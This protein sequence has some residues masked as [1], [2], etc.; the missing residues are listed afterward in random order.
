MSPAEGKFREAHEFALFAFDEPPVRTGVPDTV[1]TTYLEAVDGVGPVLAA[2]LRLVGVRSWSDLSVHSRNMRGEPG[3][4][5]E[6]AVGRLLDAIESSDVRAIASLIPKREHWRLACH[7][8]RQ[9]V[10]LDIETTGL[11]RFYHEI[12]LV[13]WSLGGDYRCMVAPIREAEKIELDE[14]LTGNVV[15]VTF[16]GSHFDLPFIRDHAGVT[17]GDVVHVDLRHLGA[18]CGLRG[19][20]KKIER[21]LGLVREGDERMTGEE[22]PALWFLFQ[23]GDRHALEAL[24]GYNHADV[25]GMRVILEWCSEAIAGNRSTFPKTDLS[26]WGKGSSFA[27]W[28]G[29]FEGLVGPRMRVSDLSDRAQQIV[30]VG[31]DLAGSA[32]GNTGWCRVHGAAAETLALRSDDEIMALTISAN[33]DLVSIDAPLSLPFGR[34]TPF[35]DDP[36]RKKFGIA[37]ECERIL[38]SR[39]VNTY[40]SLIFSMQKL[41]ERGSQLAGELRRQGIPVIESFPGAAQDM[42]GVPR[43]GLDK[44]FL[45]ISLAEYGFEGDWLDQV[46][47]HDE[48]DALTSALVGQMFWSGL[49]ELLGNEHED[50]M[51][52]PSLDMRHA[53]SAVF[54]VSGRTGAGKSTLAARLVSKGLETV[55]FSAALSDLFEGEHNRRP[56]RPELSAFG[57]EILRTGRQRELSAMVAHAVPTGKPCVVDGV[58]RPEDYTTL[59]ERF[60]AAYVHVH[61]AID[62]A[63]RVT[64]LDTRDHEE[65]GAV[66]NFTSEI[67]ARIDVLEERA[68][69]LFDNSGTVRALSGF[70]DTLVK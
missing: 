65:A 20:Q 51:V 58:R 13:G 62:E 15:V 47:T 14:I 67:E 44:K 2:K 56:T 4:R 53:H 26:S 45:K 18:R 69:Q 28:I 70:A 23:R 27:T 54:G 32:K 46:V 21:E 36:A 17:S 49:Y 1:L 60:G 8:P 43:K 39:G 24:I 66:S 33:P 34:M 41:T 64:R 59:V 22:A 29:P 9:T 7:F 31:I 42:L 63:T 61:L 3:R 50:Y 40:P 10:F 55:S 35:D 19:G 16:N 11:S 6:R 25:D 12:T 30:V 38:W 68:D 57:A 48:L 5:L 52:V 37:R